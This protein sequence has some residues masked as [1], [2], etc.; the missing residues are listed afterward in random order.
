ML[1]TSPKHFQKIE[2]LLKSDKNDEYFTRSNSLGLLNST[3]ISAKAQVF[4]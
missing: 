2:V 4:H 3:L 1:E